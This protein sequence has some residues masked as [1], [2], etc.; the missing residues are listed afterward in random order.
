MVGPKWGVR[1]ER[2]KV[3]QKGGGIGE[4]Y[5][6]LWGGVGKWER[7]WERGGE[8]IKWKVGNKRGLKV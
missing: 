3:L 2:K 8:G 1:E 7:R 4:K 6:E 5:N